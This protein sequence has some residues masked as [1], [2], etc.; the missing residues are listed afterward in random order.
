M[1]YSLKD[2]PNSSISRSAFDRANGEA[3]DPSEVQFKF[4]FIRDSP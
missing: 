4:V 3:T 2:Q 1:I